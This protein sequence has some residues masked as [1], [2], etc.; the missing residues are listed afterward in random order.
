MDFDPSGLLWAIY[1]CCSWLPWGGVLTLETIDPTTGVMTHVAELEEN[2]RRPD[3]FVTWPAAV[4]FS[5]FED[6]DTSEWSL[7]VE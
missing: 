5:S 6:G 4:L 7:A 1:D 3:G 2:A